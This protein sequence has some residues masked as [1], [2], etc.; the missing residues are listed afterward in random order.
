MISILLVKCSNFEATTRH[1]ILNAVHSQMNYRNIKIVLVF[2]KVTKKNSLYVYAVD[3]TTAKYLRYHVWLWR[4]VTHSLS[5][6]QIS[7]QKS[8]AWERPTV[9][10]RNKSISHQVKRKTLR[11]IIMIIVSHFFEMQIYYTFTA[12][13]LI[14]STMLHHFPIMAVKFRQFR[15]SLHHVIWLFKALLFF[16]S[17]SPFL[18]VSLSDVSII[19]SCWILSIP[20]NGKWNH[21]TANWNK[22]LNINHQSISIHVYSLRMKDI[23]ANYKLMTNFSFSFAND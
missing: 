5:D 13:H 7:N 17:L 20:W 8:S 23:N 6:G 12:N 19:C 22:Y 10:K 18:S 2:R 14:S 4:K 3:V 21:V 15:M 16:L 1:C 11:A 9:K